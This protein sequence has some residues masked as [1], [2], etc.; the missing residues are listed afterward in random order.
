MNRHVSLA[1][2][3]SGAIFLALAAAPASAD[4]SCPLKIEVAQTLTA[5][6]AGWTEGLERLPTELS[7][8]TV[9]DGPPEELAAL[10][11]D[12]GD[13]DD[14]TTTEFWTLAAN[15]RGYWITCHYS[16]TTVTLTRR[17][18]DSATRCEV[19][20]EKEIAFTGGQKVVRSM[21]CGREVVHATR[22]RWIVALVKVSPGRRTV[23]GNCG[24]FGES[25]KCWVSR[26]SPSLCR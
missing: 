13:E 25:G 14:K 6:A 16:S 12:G 17:L 26:Q 1:L 19:V 10:V 23:D 7:G 22:N 24:L 2:G 20:R 15:P 18:P 21:T 5:P 8:L 11:P 9:F 4:V 3:A